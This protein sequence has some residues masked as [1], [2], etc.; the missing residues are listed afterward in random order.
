MLAKSIHNSIETLI[1]QALNDIDIRHNEFIT[2]LKE[3]DKYEKVK[4]GIKDKNEHIKQ[5]INKIRQYK[6]KKLESIKN[7]YFFLL[8]IKTLEITRKNCFKRDLETIISDDSKFFWINLKDFEA[9]TESKWL[10][11]FNKQG[12]LQL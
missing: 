10:N 3:K 8:C 6:I 7:F 12:L 4:E 2:I 5:K 1:S 11:M 9:E